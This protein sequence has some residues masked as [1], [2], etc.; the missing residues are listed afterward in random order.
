MSD[1]PDVP[2]RLISFIDDHIRSVEELEVLIVMVENEDRWW[3]AQAIAQQV[4]L[5]VDV[6][7]RTLER[8]ASENLLAIRVTDDVR[9][10]FQ[11]GEPG[12]LKLTREL[13]GDYRRYHLALFRRVTDR[14]Q[15]S[16]RDFSRA[17]RIRRDDDR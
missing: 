2:E 6:A 16:V 5:A 9:Y 4:G 14:S 17:F 10:Q 8:L 11:P 3:G 1:T 12:L 7:R 13:A 15:R